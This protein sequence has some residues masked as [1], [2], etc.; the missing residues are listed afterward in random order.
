MNDETKRSARVFLSY[1]KADQTIAHEIAYH[2]MQAGLHAWLGDWELG[3][4]DSLREH[5]GSAATSSD[6]ILVLLSPAS[7]ESPW[8]RQEINS[9][10]SRELADRAI[11][12]IPILIENC[13]IPRNLADRVY[14]DWRSDR[15]KGMQRLVEQIWA[16]ASVRFSEMTPERFERLVGDLLVE[17]GFTVEAHG[18][19][20]R[21]RGYDFTAVR[22]SSA[23]SGAEKSETWLVEVKLYSN[24]RVSITALRQAVAVLAASS[25]ADK[26][27]VVTSGNITSEGRKFLEESG[28]ASRIRI[29][30]GPELTN[31]IARHPALIERYF[32]GGS[33]A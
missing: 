3:P 1:S 27:L 22:K 2:L 13:E 12:L 19:T 28:Y 18:R 9:A 4:G 33:R 11:R 16:L 26:G 31:L 5:I 21:D 24:S 17:M 10:L 25:E 20:A 8:V 30:E 29:I 32:H 23:P 14:L 7:V 6:C 15:E